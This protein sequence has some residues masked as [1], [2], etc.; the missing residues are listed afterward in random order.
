[1]DLN[2]IPDIL[3]DVLAFVKAEPATVAA[4]GFFV[5]VGLWIVAWGRKRR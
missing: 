2:W 4:I 3:D 1:M 5:L